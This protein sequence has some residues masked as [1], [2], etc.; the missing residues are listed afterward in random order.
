[1][2]DEDS[3]VGILVKKNHADIKEELKKPGFMSGYI[4][5]FVLDLQQLVNPIGK[6]TKD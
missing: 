5:R 2:M 6:E 4:D 3:E 1:M